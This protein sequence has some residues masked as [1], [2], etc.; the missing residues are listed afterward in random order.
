MPPE[1]GGGGGARRGDEKLPPHQRPDL[2]SP[3][4]VIKQRWQV[5]GRIGAG[6][7]GQI[8]RAVDIPSGRMVAVKLEA[9]TIPKSVLKMEVAVLKE[10]CEEECVARFYGCGRT[11]TFNFLV[12]SL[13][14][15]NISELRKSQPGQRF[16]LP[17]GLDVAR[18]MLEG[19]RAVH[20]HGALHR[21]I[22]PSNFAIGCG[23]EDSR[24]VYILDF[25]LARLYRTSSGSVRAPRTFAGFRGTARYASLNAHRNQE[26]SRRDD[27]VSFFYMMVELLEGRL[28]WH[29]LRD[30]KDVFPAKQMHTLASLAARL[31]PGFA[32]IAEGIDALA[33]A[34]RPNYELIMQEL[35]AMLADTHAPMPLV[36]DWEV[37]R[38]APTDDNP[39]SSQADQQDQ[40]EGAQRP[41]TARKP[42]PA[43]L[44][45]VRAPSGGGGHQHNAKRDHAQHSLSENERIAQQQ[46][47]QQEGRRSAMSVRGSEQ[48]SQ[49]V[50]KLRGGAVGDSEQAVVSQNL[51]GATAQSSRRH[52]REG[53][54]PSTSLASAASQDADESGSRGDEQ[55]G[56]VQ[57]RKDAAGDVDAEDLSAFDPQAEDLKE[58]E[59]LVLHELDAAI[60]LGRSSAKDKPRRKISPEAEVSGAAVVEGKDEAE[61]EIKG[62]VSPRPAPPRGPPP[63][64]RSSDFRRNR[65]RAPFP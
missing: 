10:M 27:L 26:L 11:P 5:A 17:T 39:R 44:R 30:K 45:P 63:T 1:D 12:M 53:G 61:G 41:V 3:G 56:A 40:G 60:E 7:F 32:R 14:G 58:L 46:Q 54:A 52:R 36:Y 23:K 49:G 9:A 16:S 8:H 35:Q 64:R 21:D 62:R 33:Y 25:G 65:F 2:V 29:A 15:Q 18:Q 50:S 13:V 37:K 42:P 4:T 55:V 31:P 28:P 48:D 51:S 22:K 38:P 20:D 34:D 59:Q 43:P 57:E 6:G 47:Q 24:R 19:I